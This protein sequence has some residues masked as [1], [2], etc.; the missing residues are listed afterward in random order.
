MSPVVRATA[1][2]LAG[3]LKIISE[4]SG[5]SNGPTV[6]DL[7]NSS[8]NILPLLPGRN[9]T[10]V[11][12]LSISDSERHHFPLCDISSDEIPD[13]FCKHPREIPISVL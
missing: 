9:K 10:G 8:I 1:A 3:V 6:T 5:G 4:L 7:N 12:T 13:L 2:T 11:F